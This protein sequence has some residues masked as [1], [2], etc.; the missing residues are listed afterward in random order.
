MYVIHRKL[1]AE[2]E[3]ALVERTQLSAERIAELLQLCLKSTYFSYN[4]E[5]Y[6][7]RQGTVMGSP[8]SSVVANMSRG[9]EQP[10]VLL[11][12]L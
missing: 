9:R 12:L 4:S 5:F 2:K 10:W 11:S 8:V 7:Q 1:P 6:E 3:E